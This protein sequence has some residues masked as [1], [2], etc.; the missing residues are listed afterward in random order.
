MNYP[1]EKFIIYRILRGDTKNE[2]NASLTRL[3]LPEINEEDFIRH[4]DKVRILGCPPAFRSVLNKRCKNPVP[5]GAIDFLKFHELDG[6]FAREEQIENYLKDEV[7]GAMDGAFIIHDAPFTRMAI[8]VL[9]FHKQ[10]AQEIA[11]LVGAGH[12]FQ[13]NEASIKMY[14]NLFFDSRKM[15]QD[16]WMN[17][18]Q[19]L[20]F[21]EREVMFA[22]LTNKLEDIKYLIKVPTNVEYSAFLKRAL[23]TA[24]YKLNYYAS[25]NTE[26]GD[27]N[28]RSWASTGINAG[29]K[30]TKFSRGDAGDLMKTLQLEFESIDSEIE[31]LDPKVASE[32]L[33]Q[34]SVFNVEKG[35]QQHIPGIDSDAPGGYIKPAD[36]NV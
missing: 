18:L 28:A 12:G 24:N 10:P 25:L 2:V 14:Q 15:K 27:R 9:L 23:E 34:A 6:L 26:A 13:T 29:E 21:R 8:H 20:L 31:G 16:D 7:I 3:C 36:D 1:F 30:Y 35:D 4:K 22:A 5:K 19:K 17:Y 32:V 33:P 11:E